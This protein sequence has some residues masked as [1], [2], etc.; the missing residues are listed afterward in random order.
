VIDQINVHRAHFF[1]LLI[2]H[3]T[4]QQTYIQLTSLAVF[5][6]R[7]HNA[8]VILDPW[9]DEGIQRANQPQ[10]C[11]YRT[12]PFAPVP[13]FSEAKKSC[14]YRHRKHLK[15]PNHPN[16]GDAH[17]ALEM[18]QAPGHYSYGA[19]STEDRKLEDNRADNSRGKNSMRQNPINFMKETHGTAQFASLTFLFFS[20]L[21]P[22]Y[23]FSLEVWK[24]LL[25]ALVK[26]VYYC[27]NRA[28]PAAKQVPKQNSQTSKKQN[29]NNSLNKKG[30]PNLPRHQN[31]QATKRVHKPK[32]GSNI[33]IVSQIEAA[34]RFSD[35]NHKKRFDCGELGDLTC[36]IHR[37]EAAYSQLLTSS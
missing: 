15:P 14:R 36:G 20:P 3:R 16:L 22:C 18:Y 9:L 19:N 11:A 32:P 31:L 34:W 1:A 26:A 28:N 35:W 8:P 6:A 25:D 33:T 12:K 13:F 37:K 24:K 2:I 30:V 17:H 7:F 5:R 27:S 29:C 4:T 10:K 21:P 23:T